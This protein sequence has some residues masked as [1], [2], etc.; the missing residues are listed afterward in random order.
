MH[1]KP[2]RV[3]RRSGGVPNTAFHAHGASEASRSSCGNAAIIRER[4]D[5]GT[6]AVQWIESSEMKADILTKPLGRKS[7]AY[8]RDKLML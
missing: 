5:D 7:F 1:S 3:V 4:I 2:L 6:L 8:H